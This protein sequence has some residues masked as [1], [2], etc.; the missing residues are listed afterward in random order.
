[1]QELARE[2]SAKAKKLGEDLAGEDGQI[3]IPVCTND[4]ITSL[5]PRQK[6]SQN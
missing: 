2:I 5:K 3:K 1:M 4:G 6:H